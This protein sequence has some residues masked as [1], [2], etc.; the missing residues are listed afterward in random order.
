[1][2]LILTLALLCLLFTGCSGTE[3]T[4]SLTSVLPTSVIPGGKAVAYGVLPAT[5]EITIGDVN[6]S[7]TPVAGGLEFVVP[8]TISA[9]SY[10]VTIN[11]KDKTFSSNLSVTP[12]LSNVWLE[13][14]K[15]FVEGLGWSNDKLDDV[16]LSVSGYSLTPTVENAR[17]SSTLPDTLA[18]GSLFVTISVKGSSSNT[19]TLNREAGSITGKVVFPATQ[20]PVL[21][22]LALKQHTVESSALTALI[23]YQ[24]PTINT[25]SEISCS[26]SKTQVLEQALRSSAATQTVQPLFTCAKANLSGLESWQ[27]ST[28]LAATRL[29]FSDSATAQTEKVRLESQGYKVEWDVPVYTDGFERIAISA[30]AVSTFEA[31]QGQWHLPLL[32]LSDTWKITKGA[33]STVAVVDTGVMLDHPDLQANLL[34]GY[35]FVENDRYPYDNAGHGTHVAGLVAANGTALGTA[36]EAKILPVRVLEG[37][38]GGSSFSVAQ[39]ILWAAGLGDIPNPN[40]AQIMN[41]SLGSDSFSGVMADAIAEVQRK[42]V[43]VVAA[44]GNAGGP[45]AYPAALLGV[46]AVTSLAGPTIAYQP[47]Y[48]SKGLGVWVTGYGGDATQDQNKDGIK[49]GIFST[50]LGGYGLRMGTSMASPQVAGLAALALAS[51]TPAHL[52]R[53]TLANTATE[54]GAMGYDLNFGHGLASGRVVGHSLPRSYVLA[55]DQDKVIAWTLVQNDGSFILNNLPAIPLTLLAASDEDG[56]ALLAEAGELSSVSLAVTPV[57]AQQIQT[58]DFTLSVA[59]E[60]HSIPLEA[61]P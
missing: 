37:T 52:V 14:D 27:A 1:M 32:G 58:S 34:P 29:E 39:G 41:L 53:D 26:D 43:V 12:Y 10:T 49:D 42:G 25:R 17:L 40:P 55:F 60:G 7:A 51:G 3:V 59:S 46:V 45:L 24:A 31:G 61:R 5:S 36:P 28:L 4:Y 13:N 33:G 23:V 2:R 9:G 56:D 47:W 50:D 19:F 54:L 6:V 44:A 48:A 16:Q 11:T 35:D 20:V 38:S 57:S 21:A 22:P 30:S 18:F 8:T 15:V